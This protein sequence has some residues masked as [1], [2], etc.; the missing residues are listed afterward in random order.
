MPREKPQSNALGDYRSLRKDYVPSGV[1][2]L[3]LLYTGGKG[4]PLGKFIEFTSVSGLG[5]TTTLLHMSAYL[6]KQQNKKVV[7]L[8]Y[9]EG[10]TEDSLLKMDLMEAYEQDKFILR[11]PVTFEKT[12][13][14]LDA[15]LLDK[16]IQIVVVDSITAILP[17]K[18]QEGSVED[19]LPGLQSRL[20]AVL[21]AKYKAAFQLAGK[22]IFWVTQRRMNINMRN[23][24]L[25]REKSAVG[26]AF[27]HFMDIRVEM[28]VS[29]RGKIKKKVMTMQGVEEIDFGVNA[30]FT[31]FKSRCGGATGVSV[32]LPVIYGRGISN[33]MSVGNI[34]VDAGLVTQS[35][36]YF[37]ANFGPYENLKFQGYVNYNKWV[38]ENYEDLYSYIVSNNL[39]FLF[40][41]V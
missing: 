29:R 25:T 7:Y 16:D 8:D 39:I 4:I 38:K 33:I 32:T 15:I 10:V 22:T 17:S 24:S 6:V 20:Q 27:E 13:A 14:L 9:E 31:A 5:K 19:S 18:I 11:N 34:M 1:L 40:K 37:I 3:D 26:K 35:G 36:A 12:E 21:L 28:T 23:A 41:E 2:L 30:D